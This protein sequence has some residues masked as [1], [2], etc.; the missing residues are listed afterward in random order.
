LRFYLHE[1]RKAGWSLRIALLVFMLF[2]VT[3]GLHRIGEVPTPVAMKLSGVA[4]VGAV[5]A[6]LL[7]FVAL[8]NIWRE[9]FTGAG[10]AVSG[11]LVGALIL[12][13]PLWS[14]PNLLS[15]PRL[16][17][18][19]TDIQSPP[20]FSKITEVRDRE[21][22]NPANFRSSSAK[23]QMEAYPDIRPLPLD[24]PTED[25]Y[26]AVREAAKNLNWRIVAENP[27]GASDTG[28]IEATHRSLIFGFTDDMVIRVV[29]A[30]NGARVDVHASAR[31]G[32]HDLG[33]NAQ[34]V[35]ELFSEVKTRLSE[36][37]RNEQIRQAIALRE[38]RL[39]KALEEKERLRLAK[40]REERKA[41]AR[42]AA[43]NRDRQI[44][45][46]GNDDQAESRSTSRVESRRVTSDGQTQNRRQRQSA[47]T[48][49]LRKFWEQL[50][51]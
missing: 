29:G 9:G 2:A 22:G 5:V 4:I 15:L 26:S 50:N 38:L 1:S 18:V 10:K 17:E 19:S 13:G 39:K 12:A 42:E 48:R 25:A 49:A 14:T 45:S 24:R 47:R 43:L 21:G 44:S 33:R 3:F 28:T 11:V 6:V 20:A 51:Q 30:G 36:I 16:Y 7:G 32:H 8:A 37:D 23:L 46:S 34:N 35:R 40:E 27:P 41:Q 31:H